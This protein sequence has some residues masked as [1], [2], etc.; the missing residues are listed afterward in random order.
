MLEEL[1]TF[2]LLVAMVGR[3]LC[4]SNDTFPFLIV[5][6]WAHRGNPDIDGMSIAPPVF[7]FVLNVETDGVRLDND[8]G[9][10]SALV[11][12]IVPFLALG[13]PGIA[14]LLVHHGVFQAAHNI[15]DTGEGIQTT[16]GTER[17]GRVGGGSNVKVVP[18]ASTLVVGVEGNHAARV[19]LEL[20]I[21]GVDVLFVIDKDF[22]GSV[23]KAVC[24]FRSTSRLDSVLV[25]HVDDNLVGRHWRSKT[26]LLEESETN[27]RDKLV[28]LGWA[29]IVFLDLHVPL[30]GR[31]RNG[32]IPCARSPVK[33]EELARKT[34]N[35]GITIHTRGG[36]I[37]GTVVVGN[38]FKVVESSRLV[39]N[40]LVEVHVKTK[41]HRAVRVLVL[42]DVYR[43]DMHL[44]VPTAEPNWTRV[45]H[46][47]R[48]PS[49][50]SD[51]ILTFKARLIL[52]EIKVSNG[53]L[54]VIDTDGKRILVARASSIPAINLVKLEL[55]S[56]AVRIGWD[57]SED[58]G[59]LRHILAVTSEELTKGAARL[60]NGCVC[61]SSTVAAG[62]ALFK[63]FRFAHRDSGN[64]RIG[65][66]N[67][68]WGR[69]NGRGAVLKDQSR[70]ARSVE[71]RVLLVGLVC[72][73]HV[74]GL[75]QKDGLDRSLGSTVHGSV[76][77]RVS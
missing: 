2:H 59:W 38:H 13:N 6:G 35:E 63:S 49:N 71:A 66:W 3:I 54:V 34:H 21:A 58:L 67:R 36:P 77:T 15:K 29:T 10:L 4:L 48:D 60:V 18:L 53:E 76:V 27:T 65:R 47:F 51:G 55:D 43:N 5:E 32:R 23:A 19:V 40:T 74:N 26:T 72:A 41:L 22:Q 42:G 30:E 33:L 39:G 62:R 70:E 56:D 75:V 46:G 14:R 45:T 37:D 17:R 52:G 24:G 69:D 20:V 12:E 50:S 68:R 25:D 1:K 11:K 28:G 16:V 9:P 64:T 44:V 8:G 7:L 73:K 31:R 57:T 61:P